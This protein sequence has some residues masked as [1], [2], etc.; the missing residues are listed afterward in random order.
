M[1]HVVRTPR[2]K[3][4]LLLGLLLAYCAT[5]LAVAS[6]YLTEL[7]R[8]A[9]PVE[10]D[11]IGIP[12]F[13]SVV[14]LL[15]MTPLVFIAGWMA[16]RNYRSSA[17]LWA[18]A[19]SRPVAAALWTTFLGAVALAQGVMA[20]GLAQTAHGLPAMYAIASAYMSLLLRASIVAG[21]ERAIERA[22]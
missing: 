14:V 11:S 19:P 6:Y 17:V 13:Q 15:T 1:I 18:W 10:A 8:G 3:W 7:R 4:S 16:V 21:L 5:P 9:Y 20:L 2:S 22:A 12:I